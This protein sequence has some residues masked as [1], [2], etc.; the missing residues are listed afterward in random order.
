MK[1]CIVT[2]GSYP[3]V[4]GGVASWIH[5]MIRSMPEVEFSVQ[6]VVADR[7]KRGDFFIPLPENVTDVSEIYLQDHDWHSQSDSALRLSGRARTALESLVFSDDVLWDEVFECFNDPKL[8]LNGLLMGQDFLRIVE[9]FY[10][11]QFSR[12]PFT[13][14][15]WTI[16]SMYLPLF[17][18][19]RSKTKKADLYH[20]VATGYSGIWA[21]MAKHFYHRPFLLSEHGIYTREREEEI[22]KAGWVKGL[23][24]DIWIQ[25]F[26]SFSTCAYRFADRV[27]ALFEGARQLQLGLGCPEKKTL[28]IPNGVQLDHYSDASPKDEN[29]PFIN[30]GAILRVAP[31]KDVKTLINAF[32]YAKQQEP[33]LKL[34]IMGPTDENEEYA[35]ECMEL[36]EYSNIPDVVFTGRIRVADYVG[37]MDMVVLSSI[38]EGQPL[39]ILEAYCAEKPCIATDVGNCF[40]LIYGEHDNLGPA[41]IGVPVM[42][43][44][45]LA[46]AMVTLA[47][48][49]PLREKMGKTGLKRVTEH[50]RLETMIAR[51]GRLYED[52]SLAYGMKI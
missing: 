30:V 45:K 31:V 12:I 27:T 8:S 24:K 47:R 11:K 50:Y 51:Y 41:G 46:E 39:T 44:S 1:V 25:Q 13:D 3:H 23:Y 21:S 16:R 18:V 22:I 28:V 14:F 48:N 52:L 42:S 26:A 40:G 6:T 5:M 33:R 36:V 10:E 2:E 37:K 38:S 7:Q 35:K 49:R 29:D 43:V 19:L 4:C 32:Y 20:S 15:L 34:W 17:M 9:G